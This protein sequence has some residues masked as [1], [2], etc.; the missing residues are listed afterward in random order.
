MGWGVFMKKGPKDMLYD[1]FWP[2][3]VFFDLDL[4]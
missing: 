4:I 1:D 3:T 2:E